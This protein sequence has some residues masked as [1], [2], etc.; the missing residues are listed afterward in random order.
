MGTEKS[1]PWVR[2]IIRMAKIFSGSNMDVMKEGGL[3]KNSL[4]RNHQP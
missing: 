2:L 4:Y 3:A 1:L